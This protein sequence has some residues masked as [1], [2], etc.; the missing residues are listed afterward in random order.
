MLESLPLVQARIYCGTFLCLVLNCGEFR[1]FGSQK[2]RWVNKV[3]RWRAGF[4]LLELKS[5]RLQ[6]AGKYSTNVEVSDLRVVIPNN[7]PGYEIQREE[8]ISRKIGLVP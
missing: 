8:F 5:L 2:T 1:V 3:Q 6:H 4:H 7:D